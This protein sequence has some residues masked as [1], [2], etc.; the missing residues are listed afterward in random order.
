MPSALT[1]RERLLAVLRHGVADRLPWAPK[2]STWFQAH[3]RRGDLPTILRGCEHWYDAARLLGVDIFDKCGPVYRPR[4]ASVRVTE[5]L[6]GRYRVTRHITPLGELS[7]VREEVEDYAH[8]VYLVE[9][10]IKRAEDLRI[11]RYL[12]EDTVYEPCYEDFLEADRRIG[13]DGLTMTNLPD[14][15]LHRIFVDLMGY[16][17]GSYAFADDPKGMDGLCQHIL[18]KNEEAYRTALDSPAEV[19]LTPENTNS[20]FESPALFRRYAF[21][22]FKRASDLAHAHGKLHWVHACGKLRALLPQFLESGIDGV[23]S[24]TPPPYA[25]TPLD[26]ARATWHGRIT[27]DGGISPHLLV[28][29]LAP[30]ELDAEVVDLLRRMAP[31][32]N[33]VLSVSDDTPTNARL[34]RIIRI[35]ELVR[36]YGKLPI[37][38][39][40]GATAATSPAEGHRD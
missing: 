24:L 1:P 20:D 11:Y 32:D 10:P 6:R 21:P 35:G 19:L 22:T 9:Y 12:L 27:I 39:S 29:D 14:S 4:F 28:E 26:L 33:F 13:D 38:A 31:G 25:D 5:D 37:D 17:V 30:G 15:P 40:I 8:T 23:E 18:E 7:T 3:E 34:E 2:F 36:E 16:E